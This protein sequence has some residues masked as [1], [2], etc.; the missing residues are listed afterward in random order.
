MANIY[1]RWHK[2]FPKPGEEPCVDHGKVPTAEH[3]MGDRWQV[4]WKEG[5]RQASRNFK[6]RS[7][8]EWQLTHLTGS[9]CLVPRCGKLAATEPPVLLCAAHRTMVVR[10]AA[11]EQKPSAIHEPVVYFARN[12]DRV[13]IGYTTNLTAR[14]TGLSLP[15][16]AVVLTF[17]GGLREE[18]ALHYRFVKARIGRSEW[19]EVTPEIEAFIAKRL[20]M[21]AEAGRGKLSA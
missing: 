10:Q 4:R 11:A 6:K 14:L 18:K 3:G 8:A 15:R 13:K 1:D 19:F 9:F 20:A 16:D 21:A 7:D 2:T 5:G 17:P 12:G